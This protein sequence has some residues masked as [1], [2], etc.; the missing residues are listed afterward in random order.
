MSVMRGEVGKSKGRGSNAL[1]NCFYKIY[2][3]VQYK[4]IYS[5][6]KYSS[7]GSYF[8]VRLDGNHL[9]IVDFFLGTPP[10]RESFI[11]KTKK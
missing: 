1:R 4:L 8:D 6:P 5:K 10:A 3:T 9:E 7:T 2:N 11:T